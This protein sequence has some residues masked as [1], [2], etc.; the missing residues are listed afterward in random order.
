MF[1][2]YKYIK[3]GVYVKESTNLDCALN[4]NKIR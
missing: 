4:D 2:I 3:W 1:V